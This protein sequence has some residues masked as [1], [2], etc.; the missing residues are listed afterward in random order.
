MSYYIAGLILHTFL[1]E[2]LTDFWVMLT[3]HVV[4]IC[5]IGFSYSTNLHRIGMLVLMVHDVSDIF[6]D[7]GKCF[8]FIKWE[9]FATVT[10]VGLISSWA[11]YRLWLY[12]TRCL[13]SSAVEAYDIM[14][15]QE[16][17]EP[18]AMYFALVGWLCI[19][20]VLHVYWF[21]LIL[22]V[23]HKHLTEGELSDV[24][25][26]EKGDKKKQKKQQ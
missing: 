2:K 17:H 26:K 8:H 16:G 1:D 12:P 25:M 9:S 18:F 14:F 22:R 20:Q 23:A 10:F 21:Y 3:H 6:L 19:L 4:T 5:L 13:Y 15:V 11:Y 24:R 7:F